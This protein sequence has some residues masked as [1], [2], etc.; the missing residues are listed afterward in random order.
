MA[1]NSGARGRTRDIGLNHQAGKGSANRSL[2][3]AF[4]EGFDRIQFP[5][6]VDGSFKRKGGK[7]V[8]TYG[9]TYSE[10]LEIVEPLPIDCGTLGVL[11]VGHYLKCECNGEALRFTLP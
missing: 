3:K 8:K 10:K 11:S 5:S 7:L 9:K 1:R 4:R 6:Q 2:S